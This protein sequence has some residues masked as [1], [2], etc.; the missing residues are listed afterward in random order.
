MFH[1]FHE[2]EGRR[3]LRASAFSSLN[4]RTDRKPLLEHP[5]K[6][7]VSLAITVSKGIPAGRLSVSLGLALLAEEKADRSPGT[8]RIPQ[9]EFVAVDRAQWPLPQ[10][11]KLQMAA[12]VSQLH[13]RS[14]CSI[15]NYNSKSLVNTLSRL[16]I[17]IHTGASNSPRSSLRK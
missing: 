1:R 3:N 8:R 2:L 17:G 7:D 15:Q 6:Q 11:W 16:M 12:L 5:T 4:K 9:E 10:S 14:Q 13:P